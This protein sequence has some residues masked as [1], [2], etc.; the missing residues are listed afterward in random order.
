MLL[1]GVKMWWGRIY[2]HKDLRSPLPFF[3]EK[4]KMKV[5]ETPSD[6]QY[7]GYWHFHVPIADAA[8]YMPSEFF[9]VSFVFVFNRNPYLLI[10]S[11]LY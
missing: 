8:Q 1:Q 4:S 2:H 10:F 9:C 7:Q 5:V 11:Q 3:A 6:G